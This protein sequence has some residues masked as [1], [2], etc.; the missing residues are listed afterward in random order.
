MNLLQVYILECS[1]GTYYTGVSNDVNI[2][3][4]QH[5]Q[6]LDK[7]AY[8][9]SR[10]PVILKWASDEM[11]PN[12]AIGVEKQIKKWSRKKKEALFN[13]EWDKLPELSICKNKS[14]HRNYK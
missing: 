10:R 14:S 9:Y 11:D 13:N 1:D 7:K 5:N 8:T 3:I 6:G 12:Q 4:E 2:R